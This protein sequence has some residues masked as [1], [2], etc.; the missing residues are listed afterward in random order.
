MGIEMHGILYENVKIGHINGTDI[1]ISEK[2]VFGGKCY[3]IKHVMC[4][5]ASSNCFKLANIQILT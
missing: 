3:T 2:S 4:E 1:E 5:K